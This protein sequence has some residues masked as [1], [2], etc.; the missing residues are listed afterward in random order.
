MEK[1]QIFIFETEI[2]RLEAYCKSLHANVF[3]LNKDD[4]LD[5]FKIRASRE[6]LIY[7]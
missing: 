1:F 7:R 3:K 4:F 6:Y 5:I 2:I